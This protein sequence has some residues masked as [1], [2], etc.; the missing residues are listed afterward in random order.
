MLSRLAVLVSLAAPLAACE[1]E[2][3]SPK[4]V[5][6]RSPVAEMTPEAVSALVARDPSAVIVDVNPREIYDEGHVPGARWMSSSDVDFDQLPKDR[7]VPLVFYCY[8]PICGA[9]HQAATTATEHG[10]KNVS[11]MPAG[12]VG[13]KASGLPVEG[14]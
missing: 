4:L 14:G 11:R 2:S 13:W 3:A 8:N 12:I 1:R 9:S 10:W 6:H 7:S 5:S